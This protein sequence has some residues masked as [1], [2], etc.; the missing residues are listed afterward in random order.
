MTEKRP[1]RGAKRCRWTAKLKSA[2]TFMYSLPA[3]PRCSAIPVSQISKTFR[4]IT[5]PRALGAA[6]QHEIK[7]RPRNKSEAGLTI[8]PLSRARCCAS[9]G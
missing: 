2:R 9:K 6:G 4:K 8:A 7:A 5:E 3:R 1:L